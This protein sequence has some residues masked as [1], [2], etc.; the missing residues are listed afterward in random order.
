MD[1]RAPTVQNWTVGAA[2]NVQIY[3]GLAPSLKR[4]FLD[5]WR[6]YCRSWIL[7]TPT[8]HHYKKNKT[9]PAGSWARPE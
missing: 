5:L 3:I 1:Y 4:S 8:T 2:A 6:L 9:G 7:P